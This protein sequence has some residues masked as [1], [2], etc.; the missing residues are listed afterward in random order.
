ML[1]VSPVATNTS[2]SSYNSTLLKSVGPSEGTKRQLSFIPTVPQ[3]A[4]EALRPGTITAA[5][6]AKF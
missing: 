5:L 3:G 4:S 2:F 1:E 6:R